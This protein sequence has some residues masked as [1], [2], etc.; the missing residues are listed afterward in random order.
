MIMVWSRVSTS[1]HVN[2][3][4][5]TIELVEPIDAPAVVVI[6]WPQAPTV[7]DPR[8]FSTVAN[9]VARILA[10]ATVRLAQIRA[11]RL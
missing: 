5:I 9:A 2:S 10:A 3:D 7:A 4:L 6:R 11:G 8:K 1:G